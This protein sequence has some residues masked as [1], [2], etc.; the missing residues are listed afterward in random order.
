[1]HAGEHFT[2]A[3]Y[4]VTLALSLDIERFGAV[5]D[6][7]WTLEFLGANRHMGHW[8]R[9]QLSQEEPSFP[10]YLAVKGF[11]VRWFTYLTVS[12]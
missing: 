3:A 1:M 10:N 11:F 2:L 5:Y 9:H 7:L 6:R 4:P 12:L 8:H